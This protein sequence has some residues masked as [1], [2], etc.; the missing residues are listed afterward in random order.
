MRVVYV[1][2]V[3]R[4]GGTERFLINLL[5][6]LPHDYQSSIVCYDNENE[7]RKELK[8]MEVD[9]NIVGKPSKVGVLRNIKEL[10][11]YF[12][13][14]QPD[15]VCAYTFYNAAYVLLAAKVC[16]VK[17]RIAHAH[18]SATEHKKTFSYR[19][20]AVA[21]KVILSIVATH[22]LACSNT[23]GKSLY[24]GKYQIIKNGIELEKYKYNM[25][26]RDEI[27]KKL[28]ISAD[29]ILLGT[30]GRL[31]KNKNQKFMLQILKACIECNIDAKLLI[32]GDGPERKS[33]EDFA[34]E[35]KIVKNVIFVGCVKNVR[36]YYDA[37]DVFL[38]TSINEG[39]PYVLIEAQANGLPVLVSS[40][41]DRTTK[42]NNNLRFLDLDAGAEY[43]ADVIRK[44][45]VMRTTP[46]KKI[47]EYSIEKTIQ[48]I[49]KI[50]EDECGAKK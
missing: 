39:F 22:K 11:R 38:L 21:S 9:V 43:W 16:G 13:K 50:Y 36:K 23:A 31:D 20:Y 49:E 1:I 2:P 46:G 26:L 48:K 35:L 29:T 42:I 34:K 14:V 10:V 44:M 47:E 45:K 32:V 41:V 7:W 5:N 28:G 24:Y 6:G 19:L 8:K 18:T 3:L 27:R 12:R 37:M 4:N 40:S 17:I 15:V 30:I 33:L 25:A